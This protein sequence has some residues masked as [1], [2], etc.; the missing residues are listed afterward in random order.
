MA[1]V[2]S[3][4][5]D[6]RPS[7]TIPAP[8]ATGQKKN[9]TTNDDAL[10]TVDTAVE[11]PGK[12]SDLTPAQ[13]TFQQAQSHSKRVYQRPTKRRPPPARPETQVARDSMIDQI[14]RESQVPLYDRSV[15]QTPPADGEYV[16][17]D[18]ATAEAF[19][20]QLLA[21]MELNRRR[22]PKTTTTTSTGPKLGGSRSQRER[23][24]AMEEGKKGD[25]SKK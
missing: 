18:A 9:A 22:P 2:D 24:R 1:Y 10:Q 7:P 17:H 4:L 5:A 6:M 21:D 13:K 19:K 14:M 8:T 11:V 20:T 23:M 16:D 15:S 25:A 3:K 12:G